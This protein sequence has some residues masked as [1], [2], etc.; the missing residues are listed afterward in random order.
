MENIELANRIKEIRKRKGLTQE[1]LAENSGVSLRTI[2]RIEKGTSSPTS[3]TLN[4]ISGAL[5]VSPDEIL[6][7]Q[8]R[9]AHEI[10][11]FFLTIIYSFC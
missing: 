1:M 5:G 8:A 10:G 6:D 4:R 9:E 11:R 7:W 3:D 2:Q